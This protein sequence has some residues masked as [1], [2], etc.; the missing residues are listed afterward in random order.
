MGANVYLKGVSGIG[1]KTATAATAIVQ[2]VQPKS[3]ARLCVRA[4][5]MTCGATATNVYF[6]TPLGGSQALSAA[7]ASG[8][9]T[10]FA[11][12]AE[13]QTS[14]NALAS[15]DYIAVQLDNGQY[16][17]TTVATGTYA[18][19]SLSAALTDTVAA[20][21]LVWGFGIATDTTHYRVVLTVS[22]QTARAIDGGLIYGS[23]KG[24]PMIVY[25]NNDAALAGSQ[26]YVA[27]DFIDK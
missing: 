25:H 6:M 7:V 5:G 26:D 21:N 18:A 19:F 22:A 8:A 2:Y 12:A 13:I 16:Q 11:T 10:G 14:A 24:A 27:I 20:G 15:A 17:F 9:T 23:A 1:Y 3:G 4:F